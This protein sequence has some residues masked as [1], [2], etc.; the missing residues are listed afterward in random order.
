MPT[1]FKG[2]ALR[3][4]SYNIRSKEQ[5]QTTHN[6]SRDT[7][8]EGTDDDEGSTAS[9]TFSDSADTDMVDPDSPLHSH[10]L[11]AGGL[12]SMPDGPPIGFFST[13]KPLVAKKVHFQDQDENTAPAS[14]TST[15]TASSS[16]S[17]QS[18]PTT[19]RSIPRTTITT[20]ETNLTQAV[21]RARSESTITAAPSSPPEAT[22]A[23]ERPRSLSTISAEPFSPVQHP[24]ATKEQ[25]AKSKMP[26]EQ[27][28][29]FQDPT[30]SGAS[31]ATQTAHGDPINSIMSST[32]PTHGHISMIPITNPETFPMWRIRPVQEMR[33]PSAHFV[34]MWSHR[35]TDGEIVQVTGDMQNGPVNHVVIDD[36]HMIKALSLR[37]GADD[38]IA[39]DDRIYNLDET[40]N[41]EIKPTPNARNLNTFLSGRLVLGRH[42]FLCWLDCRGT[43]D[44]ERAPTRVEAQEIAMETGRRLRDV[45]LEIADVWGFEK[46][47]KGEIFR[48]N[49]LA[50]LGDDPTYTAQQKEEGD[51]KLKKLEGHA[52]W[53]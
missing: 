43:A 52:V 19:K 2:R 33:Y 3:S 42:A 1:T 14:P 13:A 30:I 38:V 8:Q 26:A 31:S 27:S 34:R 32:S 21:Q 36:P 29:Q 48:N 40:Y 4:L 12:K 16:S 37:K 9:S 5:A 49:R 44:P 28:S 50:F 22:P 24:P 15:L 11:K 35:N 10:S 53:V 23:R 47:R 39:E 18:S 20:E 6:D 7:L 17:R 41:I 25:R 46:Q 45:R 51:K